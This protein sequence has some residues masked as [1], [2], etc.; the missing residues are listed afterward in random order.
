MKKP[1]VTPAIPAYS[2]IS[3]FESEIFRSFLQ[4][5]VMT[6]RQ[7]LRCSVLFTASIFFGACVILGLNVFFHY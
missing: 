6:F 5:S 1:T 3:D 4:R 7:M 2:Q